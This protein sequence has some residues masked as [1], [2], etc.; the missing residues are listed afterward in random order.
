[1][2]S[3]A[4]RSFITG[5]TLAI[6][7]SILFSA[8][9]IVVKL[10]YRHGVD[11]ATLIALRMAFSVPFFAAA[12]VWSSR[13]APP[14]TRR[15]HLK[16][17]AIGLL[18]Y[19]AASYLDFLGLQYITAA[20]ERLI[21]YLN[22]TI[23]LLMSALFLGK[24]FNRRDLAAL[25]LAYGGILLVFVN[26][27]RLEGDGVA[28]GALLVFGSAV[29][30]AAYLVMSGELVKRLGA[31]RLTSY[32]MCVSTLA[33][34]AQFLLL[35]PREPLG[36]LAQP[37]SVYWLSL[38]NGLLCTVLPVFATMLAV[39]RIGAGRASMAAMAGPVAT[40]ALAYVFLGEAVTVWQVAGTGLV[41]AGIYVLSRQSGGVPQ[42][43]AG[44][45]A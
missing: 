8:K 39:E 1:V 2:E 35:H 27:V 7:G 6:V 30:Y 33:V 11:A 31:I 3:S 41:L 20:L 21:L 37:A 25:G 29:C 4:R 36:T 34:F 22:P 38:V 19:Y 28:L 32:A 17:I 14:L 24:R 23:V 18:G 40:I 16:L 12:Y 10:A 26:D 43:R 42:V 9:A 13:G 5:L 44:K 15:D 45:E